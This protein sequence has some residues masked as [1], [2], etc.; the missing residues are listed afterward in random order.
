[1]TYMD[2]SL[3]SGWLDAIVRS[4][5]AQHAVWTV[6]SLLVCVGAVLLASRVWRSDNA[7][8]GYDELEVWAIICLLVLACA[9]VI[10]FII[11][12]S[13]AT[14]LITWLIEPRGAALREAIDIIGKR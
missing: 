11:M 8:D 9:F 7:R 3:G 5:V 6:I 4:H 10:A 1:M 12:L 14:H 2:Y 13:S